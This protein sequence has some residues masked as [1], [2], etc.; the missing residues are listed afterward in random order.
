MAVSKQTQRALHMAT[1]V[2]ARHDLGTVETQALL[3]DA[4]PALDALTLSILRLLMVHPGRASGII[5]S[6]MR[7]AYLE[8][9]EDG[10]RMEAEEPA[11]A[12][13]RDALSEEA[14]G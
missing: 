10:Q 9:V 7:V 11:L 6:H 1:D 4:N 3:A 14:K 5:Q 13:F 2:M 8:G 12:P